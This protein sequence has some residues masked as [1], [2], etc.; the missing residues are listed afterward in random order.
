[1]DPTDDA[2]ILWP[3]YPKVSVGGTPEDRDDIMGGGV[4]K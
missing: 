4:A 2:Q 3:W 1:M